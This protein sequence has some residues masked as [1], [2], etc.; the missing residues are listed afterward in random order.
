MSNAAALSLDELIRDNPEAPE[1]VFGRRVC[2]RVDSASSVN[3]AAYSPAARL[4]AYLNS[5]SFDRAVN[6]A[7]WTAF[8][9]A[10][11]LSWAASKGFTL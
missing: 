6:A 8:G 4:A 2:S 10:A 1:A 7:L 9:A 3:G 11:A 5:P